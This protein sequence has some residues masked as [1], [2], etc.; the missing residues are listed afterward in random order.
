[1]NNPDFKFGTM[2]ILYGFLPN[3]CLCNIDNIKALEK[4][5]YQGNAFLKTKFIAQMTDGVVFCALTH[6]N[7]A[8]QY[9]TFQ[10]EILNILIDQ[11]VK[12]KAAAIPPSKT[13]IEF[14][15]SL[16]SDNDRRGKREN[17]RG[18]IPNAERKRFRREKNLV[19]NEKN[20]RQFVARRNT[21]LAFYQPS[22]ERYHA[23]P[24]SC[25]LKTT[26]Q[27]ATRTH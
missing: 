27:N 12:R 25:R 8:L 14:K 17:N 1:M 20:W 10:G 4:L 21:I 19:L 3:H 15:R 11:R 16:L 2:K 7:E 9:P 22:A 23:K 6:D 26:H 18:S 24:T 13:L 5:A